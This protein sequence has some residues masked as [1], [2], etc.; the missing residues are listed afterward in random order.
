MNK[1]INKWGK[2]KKNWQI[3]KNEK[4]FIFLNWKRNTERHKKKWKKNT[5][6]IV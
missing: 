4:N 6:R 2:M 5:E 3:N 1:I